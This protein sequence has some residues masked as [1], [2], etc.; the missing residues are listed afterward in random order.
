MTTLAVPA[1]PDDI[2]SSWVGNVLGRA[3]RIGPVK[4]IGEDYGFASELY[5]VEASNGVVERLIVKLW[6]TASRAA[7]RELRF[8]E[9]LADDCPISIPVFR[10]GGVDLDNGRAFLLVDELRDVRQGDVSKLESRGSLMRL[11]RDLARLHSRWWAS[12]E[13]AER[14]WLIDMR[15][16]ERAEDWFASRSAMFLERFGALSDPAA[17]A[18]F[19]N[20]IRAHALAN[21]VLRSAPPTLLHG[22][23]HLDNIM[24]RT[25]GT[26][27]FLDWAGVGRGPGVLDVVNLAFRMGHVG[28]TQ[29]ALDAYFV[30]LQASGVRIDKDAW[31]ATVS[32]ALLRQFITWTLGMAAVHMPTER[33][34]AL[35]LPSIAQAEAAIANWYESHPGPIDE[36]I[37]S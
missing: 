33:G 15:S 12:S 17:N 18:V 3:V 11:A 4:R 31:L 27:V 1:G 2:T 30:T 32:A 5:A 13:L 37:G 19:A 25:D 8:F 34:A 35:V 36:V 6:D 10:S 16:S 29:P 26:P 21:D 22:D 23:H 20:A 9:E 28:D 24:F 14:S 7:M